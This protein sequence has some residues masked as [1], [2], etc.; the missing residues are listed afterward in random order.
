MGRLAHRDLPHDLLG[1]GI[2][3]RQ[4][5]G[6]ARTHVNEAPIGGHVHAIRATRHGVRLDHLVSCHIDLADGIGH[7]V[8]HVEM[9]AIPCSAECMGTITSLDLPNADR[10]TPR[11]IKHFDTVAS[12]QADKQ[13]LVVGAAVHI[14]RHGAGLDA[15]FDGLGG[16]VHGHQLITVLHGGVHR[17]AAAVD[18]Q[19]AGRARCGNTLH[20]RQ[21]L[22]IPAIKVHMV[23]PIGGG[24]EPLHVRAEAQV[25]R[26]HNA[27]HRALYLGRARVDERQR[28]AQGVG[29]D[30]RLFIGCQVKVV[31]LFAGGNP[32]RLRPGRRVNDADIGLQR[33]ENKQRWHRSPRAPHGQP[34]P[35]QGNTC[36]CNRKNLHRTTF[37]TVCEC[38]V[39]PTR[40]RRLQE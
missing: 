30:H 6:P 12:G 39:P 34:Q 40:T 20:Q 38:S 22:A 21:I 35:T 33:I 2:H 5:A 7:A 26:V 31:R 10:L 36:T 29:Y 18:P 14:R 1:F 27:T 37:N 25:V 17:G 28:V 32:G 8:A 23:Q 16:K 3:H 24:D 13:A 19:M 9:A 4:L 15:P 11:D